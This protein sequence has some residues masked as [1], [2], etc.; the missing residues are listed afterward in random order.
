[1][2]GVAIIQDGVLNTL[3]KAI[4]ENRQVAMRYFNPSYDEEC[5]YRIEAYLLMLRD[6]AWYVAARDT[7][8]KDKV[9]LFN[10]SRIR[11]IKL[12]DSEFEYILSDFDREKFLNEMGGTFHGKNAHDVVVEFTGPAAF[13][14]AERIWHRGQKLRHMR[15]GRLRFEVSAPHLWDIIPWILRWGGD[16]KVIKPPEPVRQITEPARKRAENYP[17]Q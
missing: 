1:M 16:A 7:A 10:L 4:R 3:Q 6:G 5:A 15:D 12:L 2:N 14:V 17:T 8:R 13:Y 9:P 11:N